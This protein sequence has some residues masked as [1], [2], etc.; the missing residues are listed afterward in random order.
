MS[1]NENILEQY[2]L[3]YDR[4]WRYND[5]LWKNFLAYGT[6]WAILVSQAQSLD[7]LRNKPWPGLVVGV[8][9]YMLSTLQLSFVSGL[10][11]A[12]VRIVRFEQENKYKLVTRNPTWTTG[13]GAY[14]IAAISMT[15]SSASL[16]FV[17]SYFINGYFLC[18][19]LTVII[20]CISSV[21]FY[22]IFTVQSDVDP[23]EP[24][25]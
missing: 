11:R 8:I 25:V 23:K 12:V 19:P 17:S 21:F 24:K 1:E 3:L 7:I 13:Y 14:A 9:T 4:N 15:I 6:S 16:C 18:L 20:L 2:R 10:G 5:L 22:K